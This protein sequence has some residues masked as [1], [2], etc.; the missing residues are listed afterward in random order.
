MQF[1]PFEAGIKRALC[2]CNEIFT[3][4]C[5]VVDGHCLGY[6]RQVGTEGNR[7]R[8]NGL[9][10]A[11]IV[12]DDMVIT[13]PRPVGAGLAPCVGDLDARY[14]TGCLDGSDDW[15][16]GLCLLVIPDSG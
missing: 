11:R 12:S 10:A 7:G 8:R 14:G 13:F 6:F 3:Y 16:E 5:D 9:P 2:C 15:R 4:A 1:Q